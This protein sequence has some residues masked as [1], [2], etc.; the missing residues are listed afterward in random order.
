MAKEFSAFTQSVAQM[1]G[2]SLTYTDAMLKKHSVTALPAARYAGDGLDAFFSDMTAQENLEP[3]RTKQ[4]FTEQC[5]PNYIVDRVLRGKDITLSA[6]PIYGDF[7]NTPASYHEALNIVTQAKQSFMQLDAHTRA[8]FENDPGVFFEF[9]NN[10]ENAQALID[11]GLA[12][13]RPSE[14]PA[15]A[16]APAAAPAAPA[17]PANGGGEGA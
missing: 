2:Q 7:T 8:K 16:P 17:A 4:E 3:T 11:M 15:P 14:S 9:V 12:I 10:P 5:D 6:N 1:F 13:A